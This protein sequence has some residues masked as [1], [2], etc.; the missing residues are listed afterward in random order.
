MYFVSRA[1]IFVTEV[2]LVSSPSNLKSSG[3]PS[4][5]LYLIES[6]GETIFQD[7]PGSLRWRP[8]TVTIVADLVLCFTQLD[9]IILSCRLNDLE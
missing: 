7:R 4:L 8:L 9:G 3:I 1:S 2:V 5:R 6:T